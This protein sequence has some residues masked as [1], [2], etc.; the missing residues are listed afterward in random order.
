MAIK[1]N[2]DK[3][4]NP[5]T[6]TIVL[7]RKNG[8]KLGQLNA[9]SIEVSD[10]LNDLSEITFNVHKYIDGKKCNLWE[11]IV[12]FKL[13]HCVEWDMWFEITVELDESTE[14]IKTVFCKRLGVAELS[15]IMLYN[16][17]INTENDIAR[18]DYI[19]PTVLY[20]TEY[21][22]SSLLHRIMEKAPHYTIIHVDDT[23]KNIQR[24]FSFSDKSI[25]D[26]FQEIAEEI[27]CLF[28]FHSNSDENGKIQRTISVYDLESYCDDCKY[29]GEFTEVCP[30]CGSKN[31]Y[32][33]YGEDTT[34]FITSDELADNI[35]LTTD[36]D[37]IKN[38]FKLEAGDDLMTATIRNCNPNGTDYLWHFSDSVK[39]DMSPELATKIAEYDDLYNMYQNE[40]I[41][42]FSDTLIGSYNALVKKY[43]KYNDKLELIKQIIIGYP[44]LINA[45]YNTIDLSVYL[46]STLMPTVSMS[47][48]SAELEAAK[49]TVRNLS[50]VSVTNID[51]IS[52]ATASN[53][54]LAMAKIVVDS[55]YKIQVETSSL[56]DDTKIWTGNFSVTNYS[57]EEDTWLSE[58]VSV[59]INDDY[60]SFVE[61]KIEKTLKK[62]DTKDFSVSG[63]FKLQQTD[64]ALELQNYSLDCLNSFYNSCQA[65]IDI[66]IEQGLADSGTWSGQEPN[67]YEDLYLPYLNR[68]SAIE[69]EVKLRQQEIDS[70][71]GIYDENK[72]LKTYGLQNYIINIKNDIQESLNFQNFV[73]S[74]LWMEFCAFRRE[75]KYSNSNYISDGLNNAELFDKANEFISVA[76]NEI[77][78]S[79][80]LQ[81]SISSTLKNLL[82]IQ[83]FKPLVKHFVV[84]NWLRVMI[85]DELYKLRLIKYTINYDNIDKITVEFSD[86]V[87]ANSSIKSVQ[88]VFSQATSMATSYSSVQRQAQQGEKSNS[89]IKNWAINGLD[90]TTTKIIGGADNQTQ[91]WD[92]H[93]MMFKK[94]D[95]IND[96]YDDIQLKIINSTIAI[97][98]DNWKTVKTAIGAYYYFDPSSKTPNIPVR[99]YG[100]NAETMVGK[101]IVGESL[102]IYNKSGSLKFDNNG[103]SVSN[104]KNTVTINPNNNSIFNIKK[105]NTNIMS[106]DENGN[107]IIIGD[108]VASSLTLLD[109]VTVNS[110]KITGLSNVALSGNY[111]D[112]VGSPELSNVALSGRYDDLDNTPNLS[113]VALS[114]QYDDLDNK[115][116]LSDVALSGDFVDLKNTPNMALYIQKDG[117]IGTT[118]Q[119]GSTG[120]L[121]SK[122]GLLQ[123]SNAI[124]YGTLYSS[125]GKIGGWYIGDNSLYS[126]TSSMSSTIAGTY[127]GIDGIRQYK[128]NAAYVDIK[129]GLIKAVGGDFSGGKITS[130]IIEGGSIS[131]KNDVNSVT[132][133]PN[134]NSI[135]NIK[136]NNNNVLSFDE[137]GNL[138]VV[139]DIVA[140]SFTL[141]E[142]A[143]IDSEKIT[144]LSS[145]A[146]SG[147]YADLDGKPTLSDVALSGKYNDLDEKPDLSKYATNE[148]LNVYIQKDGVIGTSPAEGSTGFVVTKNGLL[149]ASNA[150]IYGTLYS[151]A[152]KIGGWYIGNNSLYNGTSSTTSTTAGTYIGTD[153]VRLY[154]SSSQYINMKNGLLEVAGGTIKGSKVYGSTIRSFK[155]SSSTLNCLTSIE[156][157]KFGVYSLESYNGE[158]NYVAYPDRKF[159]ISCLSDG[160]LFLETP[161]FICENVGDSYGIKTSTGIYCEGNINTI[162]Y[163][164]TTGKLNVGGNILG[165]KTASF[166]TEGGYV[167]VYPHSTSSTTDGGEI[168]LVDAGVTNLT[169]ASQS[170][171]I[172]NYYG[173]FRIYLYDDDKKVHSMRLYKTGVL[174]VEAFTI[175]GVDVKPHTLTTNGASCYF[176]YTDSAKQFRPPYDGEVRLG[177][178]NYRWSEVWCTQS[179][180]N[181]ASDERIKDIDGD[182]EKAEELIRAI[183]PIQYKFKNGTSGRTH[184]GFGSQTFKDDL[185][186]IGLNPDKIAAFL[187]DVTEEASEK[188]IT[189]ESASEDE[190]VYGLRYSELISP[191]V[192]VIQKLLNR[193]DKLEKMIK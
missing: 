97:T 20:N 147:S 136:K 127:I 175:G 94:Y 22:E 145:V 169:E 117:I 160:H 73:G 74:E 157:G 166:C 101:L 95:S 34:I 69:K 192:S 144:G 32:E 148:S 177:L 57:D 35:Q 23:I 41:I 30:Q 17:E 129:D 109:D 62:D 167:Y 115:P 53:A 47:D 125:A 180:I 184:Y 191:M 138:I 43:Q 39:T 27:G 87:R 60:A 133:N 181:S 106:F 193:V 64:F 14:S 123:A 137:N 8:D 83:K 174:N 38:C 24:M 98:D 105:N 91:T 178:S 37:S 71:I 171:N 89:T 151:S 124:I 121:V 18:D 1:I 50:P 163:I 130:S 179:S 170:V 31:I 11:Q 119:K 156:S 4:R 61:Q 3:A 103:F 142:N 48:T 51:Y 68:L 140:S 56:D 161:W 131:I 13:V 29:R 104:G 59:V 7:A 120:F 63:L 139:G 114:G 19:I 128:N 187:C 9:K 78:K 49:L 162:G 126:G 150:I 54:V 36:V 135:I 84:G 28:V 110:E 58:V 146:L 183:H 134:N 45:Y 182:I 164:E 81:H 155:T 33:G 40:Y 107:L 26:A 79:S 118:P 10:S 93:G 12:D 77:Y 111:S 15:Q 108:I 122:E 149:Q 5:E 70:I 88:D 176:T 55:R 154:K 188:G 152:G 165:K 158:E 52:T 172:D 75:D 82:V 96:K 116:E 99:A 113:N 86:V 190:K 21:P 143:T 65:C 2:F 80:E 85:D 66:L 173:D 72:Q 16:I 46:Q 112:L 168:R 6:P 92:R 153:G 100:V 25:Y 141:I 90:A 67:L 44:S 159:E 186:S 76:K 189:L 132:I 42:T 185:I 102:G